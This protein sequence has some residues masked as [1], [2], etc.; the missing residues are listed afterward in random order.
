M[1]TMEA[2]DID[3]PTINQR[4]RK[5]MLLRCDALTI[6]EFGAVLEYEPHI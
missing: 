3:E 1:V 6:L 5:W 2:E 4:G